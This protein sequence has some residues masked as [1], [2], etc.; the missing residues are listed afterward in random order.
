MKILTVLGARPQFIKAASV[1]RKIKL[2]PILTEVI[3]HTGQHFD[4]NMSAVFFD[5]LKIPYPHY[6]LNLGGLKHGAMTGKMLIEIEEISIK[7]KPDVILVY[8]DTNSTLAGSLVAAKL[9]IKL[10]HIEAGLRSFNNEMPEEINRIIADRLSNLLFCPTQT[11]VDNLIQENFDNYDCEIFNVGD[12][13]YDASLFYEKLKKKPK[14]FDSDDFILCT[15]HRPVNSDNK[16]N[17]KKIISSLEQIAKKKDV[18]LPLHPRTKQQIQKFE[19]TIKKIKIIDPVSY[20]EMIW[21]I[22][23]SKLIITDSGGVQK[24]AFFFKKPCVTLRNE[25]EWT[26]LVNLGVNKLVNVNNESIVS[27]IENLSWY[28]SRNISSQIYGTGDASKKIIDIIK[29]A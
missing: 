14:N 13:M 4:K 17:L 10:V 16:N 15:I 22:S 9:N 7:E 8:G 24:E 12:V 21:L 1:S 5:E 2:D 26:E 29:E 23:N 20:L 25:T 11:A 27:A 18:Y 28:N 3:V 6:Q 19:I